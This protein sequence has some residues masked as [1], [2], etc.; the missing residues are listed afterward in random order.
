MEKQDFQCGFITFVLIVSYFR[1]FSD[2]IHGNAQA[3]K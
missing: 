3:C 1:N 2:C